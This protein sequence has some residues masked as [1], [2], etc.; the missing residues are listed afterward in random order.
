M[1][2]KEIWK[3]V[4]GYENLY[5]I[6]DIGRIRTYARFFR[7]HHGALCTIKPRMLRP[8]IRCGYSIQVLTDIN[9]K[10]KTFSIHRLVA[11]AFIPNPENQPEVNHKNGIR[12]DNRVENLEWATG[13]EN[14]A[15]SYKILKRKGSN[16]T[17]S[18]RKI[19]IAQL[20]YIG[21]VINEF[22]SIM[23]AEN[24]TG[25]DRFHISACAKGQRQNAG[26][27]LWI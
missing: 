15:H 12:S 9:S 2:T 6:S 27:Y 20:N 14:I 7:L 10:R 17:G 23:D 11:K 24:K 25:I 4:I 8:S 1:E 19:P 18:K 13:S 26:G 3:D 5:Q 16:T 22:K 21:I